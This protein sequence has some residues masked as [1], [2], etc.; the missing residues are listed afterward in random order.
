MIS[1]EVIMRKMA[2]MLKLRPAAQCRSQASRKDIRRDTSPIGDVLMEQVLENVTA[3]PEEA[4]T[5]RIASLP[6]T[7][8]DKVLDIR[9]KLAMGT[10]EVA[11][12]LDEAMD[13]MLE[14]II[15]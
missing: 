12:H 3:A 13:R 7:R 5:K 10:Y 4:I 6:D 1:H 11:D 2:A 14:A 15:T 8:R 9:R